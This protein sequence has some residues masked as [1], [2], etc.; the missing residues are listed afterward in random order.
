MN[1]INNIMKEYSIQG[2]EHDMIVRAISIA[3]AEDQFLD[4]YPDEEILSTMEI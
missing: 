3:D 2:E 4:M 1:Q